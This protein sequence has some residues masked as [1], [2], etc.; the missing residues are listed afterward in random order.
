M[1][2][3]RDVNF[4]FKTAA[5]LANALKMDFFPDL[6]ERETDDTP[7]SHQAGRD[8]CHPSS[9]IASQCSL[10]SGDMTRPLCVMPYDAHGMAAGGDGSATFDDDAVAVNDLCSRLGRDRVAP[11]KIGEHPLM[12]REV[13]DLAP[14]FADLSQVSLATALVTAASLVT[15]CQHKLSAAFGADFLYHFAALLFA[16]RRR[17]ANRCWRFTAQSIHRLAAI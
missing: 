6:R 3:S 9:D 7:D 10:C 11:T 13:L 1:N 2:R 17:F 16:R 8:A 15:V 12:W 4:S 5:K 14:A